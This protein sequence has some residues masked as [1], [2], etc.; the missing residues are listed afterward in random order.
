MASEASGP[1]ALPSCISC[2]LRVNQ[3]ERSPSSTE[4]ANKASIAGLVIAQYAP[5]SSMAAHS[6]PKPPPS[7]TA[8][9]LTAAAT[10][11]TAEPRRRS[12]CRGALSAA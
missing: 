12:T 8:R 5:H 3:S 4:S 11:P 6:A 7:P 10:R 1:A 9:A 2:A